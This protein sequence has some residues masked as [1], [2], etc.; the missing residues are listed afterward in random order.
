M[1]TEAVLDGGAPAPVAPVSAPITA[2]I[3][4]PNALGSQVPPVE[5]PAAVIDDKPKTA[6]DAVRSAMEKV[7]AK[8]AAKEAEPKDAP[9]VEAK[10]VAERAADGKF[11]PKAVDGQ[12]PGETPPVAATAQAT[13]T[14]AEP[15]T[16]HEAPSRFDAAAKAEWAT[17]PESVKGAVHRTIREMEAG[18]EEHRARWEPIRQYDDMAKQYGTDLP[19]ALE[20]YV[21][22]DKLLNQDLGQGLE[23]IIRDKTSGQYGL[24]DF[25][26]Q[27]TGQQPEQQQS[28]NDGV[29]HGL[30]QKVAELEQRLGGVTGHIRSQVETSTTHEVQAFS[31]DKPDFEPLAGKI[32]EHIGSG[33]SLEAAYT[34]ARTEAQELA[35]SLGFVPA[36]TVSEAAHTGVTPMPLKPAGQK[37]VFGAPATGSDPAS[38]SR[39]AP[40]PSI[41]EALKR[42]AARAG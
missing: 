11:A 22:M 18:I 39:T 31:A 8:E 6:G 19:A 12:T 7:K 37:S 14:K 23:S 24:R 33:L 15:G 25:I 17:A 2:P 41:R 28:Q 26:G 21:A 40:V 3:D 42:A 4:V 38:S 1:S 20:R 13:A 27:I 16:I 29:I 10:P 9:K 5:K 30:N 34:K 32:V 35:R 36:N